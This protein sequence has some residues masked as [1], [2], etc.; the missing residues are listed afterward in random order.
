MEK[1]AE[2]MIANFLPRFGQGA[3]NSNSSVQQPI[4]IKSK[5]NKQES[6]VYV[7]M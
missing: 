7:Y 6:Q 5:R 2:C 4:E 3:C 1:R